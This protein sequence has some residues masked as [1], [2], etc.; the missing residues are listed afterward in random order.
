MPRLDRMRFH[1]R[2]HFATSVWRNDKL[3]LSLRVVS[4]QRGIGGKFILADGADIERTPRQGIACRWL[5]VDVPM[6]EPSFCNIP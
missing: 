5:A 2:A 4:P 1:L 3:P 6:N